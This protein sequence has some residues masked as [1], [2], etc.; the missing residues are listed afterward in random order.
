MTGLAAL[1]VETQKY[2]LVTFAIDCSNVFSV[3]MAGGG[4]KPGIVLGS[5]TQN[6]AEV[7]TRPVHMYEIL[8]TIYQQLGVSTDAIFHDLSNRPM[9]VLSK[10]MRAVE[11][12]L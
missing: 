8:A 11:E 10:P 5:S 4:I 2:F 7:R 12:L 9:P 1:S 6:G 3:L